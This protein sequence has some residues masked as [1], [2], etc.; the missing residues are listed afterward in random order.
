MKW[1]RIQKVHQSFSPQAYYNF[2]EVLGFGSEESTSENLRVKQSRG[3]I[4]ELAPLSELVL[5][6]DFSTAS[7]YLES[8]K[9]M[10]GEDGFSFQQEILNILRRCQVIDLHT[11]YRNLEAAFFRNSQKVTSEQE[12]DCPDL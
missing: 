3:Y 5:Q 2:K 7:L 1:E 6:N 10:Q 8:I 11:L 4:N 12:P 9:Q